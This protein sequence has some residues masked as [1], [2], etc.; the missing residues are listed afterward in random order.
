MGVSEVLTKQ[1]QNNLKEKIKCRL[2]IKCS[3]CGK[4]KMKREFSYIKTYMG[5]ICMDCQEQDNY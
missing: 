4:R 2:M 1:E 3:S 5:N